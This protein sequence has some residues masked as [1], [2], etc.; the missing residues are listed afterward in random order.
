MFV[1]IFLAKFLPTF[2]L[3]FAKMQRRDHI[4][5]IKKFF[6]LAKIVFIPTLFGCISFHAW[7]YE[8]NLSRFVEMQ[9]VTF[10]ANFQSSGARE[11]KKVTKWKKIT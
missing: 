1:T 11:E 9:K 6:I 5:K 2:M 7:Q 8:A 10:F 4:L 3:I